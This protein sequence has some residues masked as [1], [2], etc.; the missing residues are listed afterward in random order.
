M[1][2]AG[3][4]D[5]QEDPAWG[6]KEGEVT[7]VQVGLGWIELAA[8]L[9]APTDTTSW[10]YKS[11]SWPL[12]LFISMESGRYDRLHEFKVVGRGRSI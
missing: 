10:Q 2:L 3:Y 7:V 11:P 12:E 1:G 4:D 9:Q 5:G 8:I 6:R